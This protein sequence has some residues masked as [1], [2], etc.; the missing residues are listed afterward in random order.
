MSPA[1]V[2]EICPNYPKKEPLALCWNRQGQK[3]AALLKQTAETD[4]QTT[5]RNYFIFG[6]GI[7]LVLVI[8]IL[9]GYRQKQKANE[10]IASQ[11]KEVE[12]QKELIEEKQKEIVDSI[13]YA[14][15]LQQAILP[16]INFVKEYIPAS[17][18]LFK[19]KDI[20]A[21]DFYWMEVVQFESKK[22]DEH[23]SQNSELILFAAADC[24]GHG[25]PGAMVSVVCS[26]ALNRTVKEFAINE[27]AKILDKVRDLV[28]ETF[29]KSES[30]VK[31]GMDISLCAI[32]LKSKN[33]LW[34]GANNPL[35]IIR[36]NE[37][38]E[39]KPNKQ[40]IGKTESP[41]PFSNHTIKLE[42]GDSLYLF[43][44]GYADQFGGV[45]GKK[46]K[47]KK[48]QELL[49]QIN[50][51]SMQEQEHILNDKINSWKGILEQVD[52]ILIVGIKI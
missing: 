10:I 52:D 6:F 47:Y 37:L 30:E 11:K 29:Q 21:G 12:K 13:T 46:F 39:F 18:I 22:K 8:F 50:N 4:K 24:T 23:T 49:L 32:D 14:K 17:F 45:K 41:Q 38:L 25:V 16:P 48:M 7:M 40:P 28:I 27:P 9:R 20:V 34:A 1:A 26:N 44:D 3:N 33:M 42:E 15:R 2:L 35:W 5:Q 51:K 43:T 31:D 19:P 36:N